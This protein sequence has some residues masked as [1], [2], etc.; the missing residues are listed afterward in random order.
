MSSR[1][2]SVSI[3]D[4]TL[5]DYLESAENKSEL[6]REGV[7]EIA[8]SSTVTKFEGFDQDK[9]DAWEWLSSK[10]SWVD[11]RIAETH[12]A[13]KTQV[14]KQLVREDI[15]KPLESAGL[16]KRQ[17]GLEV[18]CIRSVRPIECMDCGADIP[19][20]RFETHIKDLHSIEG[21]SK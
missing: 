20:N 1:T 7:R 13:Q 6:I 16:L 19:P 15:I 2:F 18:V 11:I 9:R 21:D 10:D 17:A 14:T 4:P 3:S 5:V 8:Q 12:I